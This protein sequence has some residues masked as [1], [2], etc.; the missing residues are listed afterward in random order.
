[1]LF[2]DQQI[3]DWERIAGNFGV[4]VVLLI[5]FLGGVVWATREFWSVFKPPAVEAING[6]IKFL[7]TSTETMEV[8]KNHLEESSRCRVAHRHLGNAVLAVAPDERRD[9]VAPH[10]EAL[11]RELDK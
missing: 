5:L 9:K 1:M 7:Q 10:I 8:V 4:P 3:T 2:A 6:H 11:H